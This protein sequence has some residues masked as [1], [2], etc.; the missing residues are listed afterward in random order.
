M[1]RTSPIHG[2]CCNCSYWKTITGEMCTAARMHALHMAPAW[3]SLL[4]SARCMASGKQTQWVEFFWQTACWRQMPVKWLLY[5]CSLTRMAE[6][7]LCS[8]SCSSNYC[9]VSFTFSFRGALIICTTPSSAWRTKKSGHY[10]DRKVL[11]LQWEAWS[12]RTGAW[13]PCFSRDM[14]ERTCD[15]DGVFN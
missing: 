9:T 14:A 11:T 2:S 1:S 3:C 12:G 4:C 5:S 10:S 15:P 8:W 7:L 13:V 6:A